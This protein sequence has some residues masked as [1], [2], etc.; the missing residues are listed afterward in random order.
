MPPGRDQSTKRHSATNNKL[1]RPEKAALCAYID[2]LDY[3]NLAVNPGYIA[4]A[5]NAILLAKAKNPQKLEK[6]DKVGPNWATRFIK[7]HGYTKARQKTL[8]SARSV[9]EDVNTVL[10]CFQ[11]LGDIIKEKG[12][13]EDIWNMDE[14]GF[15]IGINKEKFVVTNGRRRPR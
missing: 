6:S 2:R 8:A 11:K 12:I 15:R 14:T 5:A 4:P 1:T 9:S 7:R 13:N 10:D 3:V